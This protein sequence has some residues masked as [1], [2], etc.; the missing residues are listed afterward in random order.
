MVLAIFIHYKG[1]VTCAVFP[2]TLIS[3]KTSTEI[4]SFSVSTQRFGCTVICIRAGA[5]IGIWCIKKKMAR[6]VT[7]RSIHLIGAG[8]GKYGRTWRQPQKEFLVRWKNCSGLTFYHTKIKQAREPWWYFCPLNF[9]KFHTWK[10]IFMLI[11]QRGLAL[12]RI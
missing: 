12:G 4:G 9:I 1:L 11:T 2:T 3:R 8:Q 7:F 6:N 5:F 10:N